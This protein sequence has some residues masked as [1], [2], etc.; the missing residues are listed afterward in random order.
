MRKFIRVCSVSEIPEGTAK[1]VK[2]EGKPIAIFNLNGGLYATDKP[3]PTR[4][5]P[6][7]T[8]LLRERT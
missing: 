1:L 6:F 4:V 8:G 3:V 7:L 2:V 5:G